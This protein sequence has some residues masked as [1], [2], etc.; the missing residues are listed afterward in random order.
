VARERLGIGALSSTAGVMSSSLI[1]AF[2]SA[3]FVT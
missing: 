3:A 1:R 2:I